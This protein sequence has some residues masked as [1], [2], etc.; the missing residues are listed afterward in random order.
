MVND[1]EL[2]ERLLEKILHE[3]VPD[4]RD[5]IS[6]TIEREVAKTLTRTLL[7]SE[8]HQRLNQ[9]M[10]QGLQD[11]YKEINKAAKHDGEHI[12]QGDRQQTDQLFQEAAQQLDKI[13]QTTESATTDI[14]DIVEKHMDLQARAT[15][16]LD[17]LE[18]GQAAPEAVA[19]LRESNAALGDDLMRIMTTLSFQDL[20]GQRI[21]RIIEAIKK[22]EQIVLDLYL[23]TGL[24]MK[25]WAEE[26]EKDIKVLETEAKQKVS[27]LKGPQ[28]KV[29][30]GDVDDLLSQLGLD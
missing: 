2:V 22:V 7:E 20:T 21:K 29:Q 16:D 24:Q 15:G 30:Q 9:E 4:L 1:N 27:A 12:P 18:Q 28:S 23:S 8:F 26:P 6:A 19:R 25:A 11:I 14:M 17:A 13:L 3:V 5:S 10:R